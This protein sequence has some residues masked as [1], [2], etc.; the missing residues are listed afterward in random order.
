[1]AALKKQLAAAKAGKQQQGQ[2]QGEEG[3][4]GAGAG[5]EG[6]GG[7]GVP[8]EWGRILTEDDFDKIR[9]L[10]H[11]RLVEQAMQVGGQARRGGGRLVGPW[12]EAGATG[13]ARMLVGSAWRAKHRIR[14][15]RMCA[16]APPRPALA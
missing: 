10:K 4:A 6:A 14:H 16:P 13:Q 9:Q 2:G 3:A 1:M 11:R 8:L 5:A 12:E 7:E 15:A